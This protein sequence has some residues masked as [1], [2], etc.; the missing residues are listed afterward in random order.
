LFRPEAENL[1]DSFERERV[2]TADDI[3]DAGSG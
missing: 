2:I 1:A 3:G